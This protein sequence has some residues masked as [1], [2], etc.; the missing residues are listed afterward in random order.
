V[1][2]DPTLPYRIA[3]GLTVLAMFL[4]ADVR[5]HGRASRRL[6]EYGFIA[7]VTVGAMAF[8]LLHDAVIYTLSPEYYIVGKR[9]PGAADG[10]FP[11]IALLALQATWTAGLIGGVVLVMANNPSPE[12]ERVSW[13]RLMRVAVGILVI[14]V[15]CEA[16]AGL[17]SYMAANTLADAPGWGQV[18][19]QSWG[20]RFMVAVGMHYGVY[21]GG[22][23]GLVVAVVRIRRARDQT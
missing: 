18:M 15:G 23:A 6:R 8:G 9:L 7:F 17:L 1:T 5:K 11:D 16:A 19:T 3:A 2:T 10:F 13:R 20:R 4:A 12:R 22:I 21:L 14:A